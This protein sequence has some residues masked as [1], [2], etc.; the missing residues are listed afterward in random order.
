MIGIILE[1]EYIEI[2]QFARM[3]RRPAPIAA[4]GKKESKAAFGAI[5]GHKNRDLMLTKFRRF[6]LPAAISGQKAAEMPAEIANFI[7][8]ALTQWQIKDRDAAIFFGGSMCFFVEY[9][10]FGE[11]NKNFRERRRMKVEAL[12]GAAAEEYITEDIFYP[13]KNEARKAV[14]TGVRRDYL[15]T[16]IDSLK[17]RGYIVKFAGSALAAYAD[18]IGTFET[19]WEKTPGNDS[20]T[21][22]EGSVRSSKPPCIIGVD[23]GNARFR[24]A[25]YGPSGLEGLEE[26][27]AKFPVAVVV[28]RTEEIL[29]KKRILQ[30]I[31]SGESEQTEKLKEILKD[32]YDIE[33]VV[34]NAAAAGTNTGEDSALGDET[35]QN[36]PQ[37]SSL[38]LSGELEGREKIVPVLFASASA[39]R[40]IKRARNYLYGGSDK[41]RFADA[42]RYLLIAAV[43]VVLVLAAM[44]P[45]YRG[46]LLAETEGNRTQIAAPEYADAARALTE[47]RALINRFQSYGESEALVQRSRTEYA[48]LLET[49]DDGLISGAAISEIVYDAQSGLI[50]DCVLTDIKEFDRQKAVINDSRLLG[51]AELVPRETIGSGASV[52]Y[53]LQLKIDIPQT[54]DITVPYSDPSDDV[55]EEAGGLAQ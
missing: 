8:D 15:S 29:E 35:V 5:N 39:G 28:L 27:A 18:V 40:T 16:L 34:P 53:R 26:S 31:L 17:K 20:E 9:Y 46:A 45:V 21:V 11:S 14:V 37:V 52:A 38:I 4:S 32:K 19:T 2:S 42:T 50:I 55:S 49:L 13:E 6:V 54:P 47:N 36:R 23:V 1:K 22:P 25:L 30:L 3:T 51:V 43:L 44:P 10:Q 12:L 41:R 33:V 7:A 24:L 48:A